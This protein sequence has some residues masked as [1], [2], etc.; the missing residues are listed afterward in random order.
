[1]GPREFAQKH[2]HERFGGMQARAAIARVPC[3]GADVLLM[4]EPFAA[5]D[6][7][8]RF[9]MLSFLLDIWQGSGK[10]GVFVTHHIDEAV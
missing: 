2:P 5:H 4:G 7:Q 9:Q 8:A 1:M 6:V 10:T 3:L